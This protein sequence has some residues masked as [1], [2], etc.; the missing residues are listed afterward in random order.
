MNTLIDP[1]RFSRPELI[2]RRLV[3]LL[4]FFLKLLGYDYIEAESP[5]TTV[6]ETAFYFKA[7]NYLD[8]STKLVIECAGIMSLNDIQINDFIGYLYFNDSLVKKKDFGY[9]KMED[10]R[11]QFFDYIQDCIAKEFQIPTK[12]AGYAFPL[13]LTI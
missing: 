13:D 4:R 12:K 10:D 9:H 2:R 6:L 5:T 3:V 8:A 11:F 1:V 7:A